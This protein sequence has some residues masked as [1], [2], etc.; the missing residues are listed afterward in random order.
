MYSLLF[1][2]LYDAAIGIY[3]FL[4]RLKALTSLKAAQWLEGRRYLKE[5]LRN[6]ESA[7]PR[8]WM[9]CASAGEFEQ[10]RP[11]LEALRQRYPQFRYV[12]TFFSPSGYER[13]RSDPLA[14]E[15]FYLPADRKSAMRE[16]LNGLEPQLLILV[17]YEFWYR[18]LQ[19]LNRKQI[20]VMVVAAYFTKNH[21][22][23]HPLFRPV[24]DVLR[25]SARLMVQDESS[26]RLLQQ[27]GFEQVVVCGDSRADRVLQIASADGDLPLAE[28]FVGSARVVVA[29]STWP[30][31]ER[32]LFNAFARLP[33]VWKLIIV[34]HELSHNHLHRLVRMAGREACLY[35]QADGNG[36]HRILIVDRMGLLARLYRYATVTYVGGGFDAGIHNVLEAAVY[37]KP[38]IFG[39]RYHRFGEAKE[40]LEQGVACSVRDADSLHH[41]I[42][43]M[44]ADEQ[45]RAASANRTLV[46]RRSGAAACMLN[47]LEPLLK[48]AAGGFTGT[49]AESAS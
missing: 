48:T 44:A 12:V 47:H 22:L 26:L 31:D 49:S 21:Y 19:E 9:H 13:Y 37:G 16:F 45:L 39:P 1:G 23:F 3:V 20:P 4:I 24:R 25:Q 6:L 5:Q 15:V 42:N 34:P 10:G 18:M 29:G 8:I 43:R 27:R 40:L 7:R 41:A 35:S 11:L 30:R 17:K 46:V 36:P 32:L 2:W 33:D 14:D 28:S 38:V